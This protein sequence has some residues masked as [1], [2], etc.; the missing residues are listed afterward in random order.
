[1]FVRTHQHRRV[2]L[3][4]AR[5]PGKPVGAIARKRKKI[6]HARW[7]EAAFDPEGAL[8]GDPLPAPVDLYDPLADQAL[9]EVFVRR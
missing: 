5:E 9:A 3:A 7:R 6:G 1:M 4:E 2:L 8:V